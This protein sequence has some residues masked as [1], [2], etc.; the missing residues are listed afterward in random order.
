MTREAVMEIIG[1]GAF[2]GA[3]AAAA[4]VETHISWV[5]LDEHWAYKIKKPVRFSFLDFSS[6][7]KRWYYCQQELKLNK[8]LAPDMYHRVLPV[9]YSDNGYFIGTDKG[10]TVD[11]ALQMR[12]QDNNR[13]MN[14]L[15]EVGRVTLSQL[16]QLASM[17][18]AFHRQTN[19]IT[20][21]V[22]I[23]A[24]H[25]DFADLSTT[26]PIIRKHWGSDIENQVQEAIEKAGLFL[27]KH[28][29]RIQERAE[30]G[31]IV[32]GHGDL[33]SRNIFLSDPPVIFD[34][35]EFNDAIRH[36]DVLNEIAFLC[37]DLDFYA[38]P[39]LANYF[40]QAYHTYYPCLITDEDHAIL[41]YY[42]RYR[43]NI[44]LKV[45]LLEVGQANAESATNAVRLSQARRYATL[46][47]LR[48]NG[49]GN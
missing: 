2:P 31:F 23:E 11:Y 39:D 42:R 20:R 21:P 19:K 6:L 35:I 27:Q 17:L 41:A 25:A 37:L 1:N 3:T 44:R 48:F 4:L 10:I 5:I 8:R 36:V 24:M 14:K 49:T 22:D 26:L 29:K 43:A 13:Q 15:L 30:A 7:E 34:C 38:Y 45:T 32:D 12:R 47:G 33:H 9:G 46:M 16:D 40:V 28:K 18:A